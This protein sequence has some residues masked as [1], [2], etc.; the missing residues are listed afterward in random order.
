[1]GDHE[2]LWPRSVTSIA[3]GKGADLRSTQVVEPTS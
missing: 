2:G 1:M 3:R